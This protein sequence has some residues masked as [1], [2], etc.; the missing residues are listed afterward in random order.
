EHDHDEGDPRPPAAP[1]PRPCWRALVTLSRREALVSGIGR[2]SRRSLI[3]LVPPIVLICLVSL[4]GGEPRGGVLVLLVGLGALAGREGRP[5]RGSL[6]RRV[7]PRRLGVVLVT[8]VLLR[9]L[10]LLG[11]LWLLPPLRN[12]LGGSGAHAAPPVV[13]T[14]MTRSPRHISAI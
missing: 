6:P 14:M 7:L 1:P 3:A 11:A 12:R 2:R 5:G 13:R 9:P 4:A 10:V 8:L